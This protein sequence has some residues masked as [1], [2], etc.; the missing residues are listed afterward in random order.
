MK[1]TIGQKENSSKKGYFKPVTAGRVREFIRRLS[2][3]WIIPRVFSLVPTGLHLDAPGF[4][5]INF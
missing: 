3:V 2:G 4:P 1:K 5:G